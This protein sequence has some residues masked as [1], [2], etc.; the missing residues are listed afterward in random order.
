MEEKDII[1]YHQNDLVNKFN[2]IY[3][4][5]QVNGKN[6]NSIETLDFIGASSISLISLN[7]PDIY[8]VYYKNGF[9]ISACDEL[10]LITWVL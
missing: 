9:L 7:A 3:F 2:D 6:T 10:S 1:F 8:T 4:Y 5:I